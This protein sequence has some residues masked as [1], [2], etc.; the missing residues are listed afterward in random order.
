MKEL[1]DLLGSSEPRW[2]DPHFYDELIWK[3]FSEVGLHA[4]LELA[5]E[6]K[7][8]F[9]E[10]QGQARVVAAE[11]LI[12]M[13]LEAV[14]MMAGREALMVAYRGSETAAQNDRGDALR[15]LLPRLHLASKLFKSVEAPGDP[16]SVTALLFETLA[17]AN[18]DAPRLLARI[19]G[20][21]GKLTN[22]YRSSHH[23]L[24]ALQWDRVLAY[25]GVA[26]ALR[27]GQIQVAYGSEWTRIQGWPAQVADSLGPALTNMLLNFAGQA[28]DPV[29]CQPGVRENYLPLLEKDGAAFLNEERQR[30]RKV[31]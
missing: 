5:A 9:A 14:V 7:K 24:R 23:R 2:E 3:N 15:L 25:W 30:G 8:D 26:P 22:K 28:L 18:G 27:H 11:R 29:F 20:R 31:R 13:L 10:A 19:G 16:G 4:L 12:E 17:V 21:E 1:S 6:Q